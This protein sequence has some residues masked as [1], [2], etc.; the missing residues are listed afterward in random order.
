MV[1]YVNIK[2]EKVDIVMFHYISFLKKKLFTKD[3]GKM[4]FH[5]GRETFCWK[6]DIILREILIWA[7]LNVKKVC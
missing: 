6:A 7:K 4:V 3:I 2:I 1:S 5:M